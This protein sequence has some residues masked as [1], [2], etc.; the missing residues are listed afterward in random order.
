MDTKKLELDV[1]RI[2]ES[3][4]NKEG[5]L[6]MILHQVHNLH[7]YI[8]RE[9]S[10]QVAKMLDI[11]LAAIYEVITFYNYFKLVPPGK[12]TISVCM[13]TACYLKGSLLLLDEVKSVLGIN[14]GE[15]TKSGLFHLQVVRCLGCCGLSPVLTVDGVVYSKVKRNDIIDIISKHSDGLPIKDISN[16]LW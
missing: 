16:Y 12:H 4:R 3:W 13:G 9:A 15:T 6:I 14:E 2:V 7:G 10:F 5:N 1:A 11:P 8:P